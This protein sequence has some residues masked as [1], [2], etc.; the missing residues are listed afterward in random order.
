MNEE[1]GES[2]RRRDDSV[3]EDEWERYGEGEIVRG[4]ERDS[5]YEVW[6]V[7]DNT[8]LKRCH[9]FSENQILFTLHNKTDILNIT[10]I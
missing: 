8:S 10:D 4:S 9:S 7:W 1:E 5:E 3:R 6:R 2:E